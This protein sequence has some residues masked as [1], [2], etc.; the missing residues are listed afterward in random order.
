MEIAGPVRLPAVEA[1]MVKMPAPMTTETP[2][3]V[4]IP[5]VQVLRSRVPGLSVSAI[6]CLTDFVRHRPVIFS[7]PPDRPDSGNLPIRLSIDGEDR[8]TRARHRR[9]HRW[10]VRRPSAVGFL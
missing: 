2:K 10:A 9:Q 6:D 4:R 7:L 1:V 5:P 8:R 3:T